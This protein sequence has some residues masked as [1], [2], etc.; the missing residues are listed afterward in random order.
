MAGQDSAQLI[1]DADLVVDVA[2]SLGRLAKNRDLANLVAAAKAK[3]EGETLSPEEVARLQLALNDALADLDPITLG[4]LRHGW[5]PYRWTGV[6]RW[7]FAGILVICLIVLVYTG[8]L[9]LIYERTSSFFSSVSALQTAKN[10]EMAESI[11]LMVRDAD[12]TPEKSAKAYAEAIRSFADLRQQSMLTS[13]YGEI[14]SDINGS[15]YLFDLANNVIG[16]LLV[17]P[18]EFLDQAVPAYLQLCPPAAGSGSSRS[19]PC[20]APAA[21]PV[22]A[23]GNAVEERRAAAEQELEKQCAQGVAADG[24][25]DR[26]KSIHCALRDHIKELTL[27]MRSLAIDFDPMSRRNYTSDLYHLKSNMDL[28]GRW[29]LPALY[30]V[31]GSMVFFMRHYVD[32]AVPDPPLRKLVHRLLLG[33]IAGVIA[34][35]FW[36]PSSQKADAIQFTSLGAF[37]VAFLVGFSTDV[38]FSALDRLSKMLSDALG[39]PAGG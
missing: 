32:R 25:G 13:S 39:K 8:Y 29:I 9:T 33:G 31:F 14:A 10:E 22:K 27:V 6:E 38:L 36:S 16:G 23:V 20:V 19:T 7:R 3:P 30:G 11:Y 26:R 34:V 35:W 17:V 21:A 12:S 5:R 37:G 28:I 15:L 1:A 2:A 24:S 18:F 4:D